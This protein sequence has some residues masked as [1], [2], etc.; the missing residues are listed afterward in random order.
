MAI[1]VYTEFF[2]LCLVLRPWTGL[3]VQLSVLVDV[4]EASGWAHITSESV[5]TVA[6]AQR[7][8]LSMKLLP[9]VNQVA[10]ASGR[11]TSVRFDLAP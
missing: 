6:P 10:S 2:F 1:C 7:R 9:S 8:P 5:V 4:P 11:G 3:P